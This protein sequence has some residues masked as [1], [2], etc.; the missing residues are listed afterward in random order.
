V[1][2][3]PLG[4]RVGPAAASTETPP[5]FKVAF[6]GDQ[7]L[8]TDAQAVLSLIAGEGADMVLHQGD[9]GY[10]VE[11]DPQA[12][13]DWDTQ[14]SAILGADF[15]YFASIGN[16]DA[17]NWL[18]YQQLLLDRLALIPG[19]TCSGDY[20][21]QAACSYQGLFF[22]LSGAGT[23]PI[24][25]DY[26]PHVTYIR[27]QLAQDDSIWRICSW[28]KNQ[29][30]MQ[31]GSMFDAVGWGP[32]EECREGGA[33]IATAH[34]HSY[35]RTKTLSS[36]Q[37]QTVDPL[38]PDPDLLRVGNGSTLVFVS[39]LGGRSIR[40]QDRCLPATPPY[41]CNGEWASIYTSHQGATHG[42]LFIEFNVDGDPRKAMGYFKTIAGETI[43][44]FTIIAAPPKQPDPGDSD[45]DGCTDQQ[46]NGPSPQLGGQRDYLN[47]WDF[48]DVW[49][50]PVGDPS[51]W[52]R[53][54]GIDL[55]GDIF[56]V[57]RRFGASDDDANAPVNRNSDPLVPPA[58][59][60]ETGY[61]PAFDRGAQIGPNP[62][63][64]APADGAIDL[65]NDIFSMARQFGHSCA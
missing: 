48:Y 42:A 2:P 58:L 64:L 54:K 7:G 46:E 5:N 15:P 25:P 36:T 47:F 16:H 57:A 27:E 41:G 24:Q 34:E 53:S 51:G 10:G 56:G 35:Q 22:I 38:W 20:G 44:S 4:D 18:T 6:I 49:T 11:S 23:Q 62:W 33:I 19:A 50:R 17:I 29:N 59:D 31:V 60:N 12:A 8:G 45:S 3:L 14:V 39:G 63:N 65:F 37:L 9:L 40:D 28:H 13:V 30:A 32:Y 21:V 43:D 52:E 1:N 61:H 26:E 55:F